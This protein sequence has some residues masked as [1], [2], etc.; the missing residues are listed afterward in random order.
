[1]YR[2][3]CQNSNIIPNVIVQSIAKELCSELIVHSP[4]FR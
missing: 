1:M 2:I 4:N 3:E